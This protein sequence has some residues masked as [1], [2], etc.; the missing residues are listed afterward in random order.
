MPRVVVTTRLG[1]EKVVQVNAGLSLM[2]GLRAAGIDEI[3]AV[4]GGCAACCTCHVYIQADRLNEL[5][6]ISEQED[7]LLDSS[8]ARTECS[9][10]S[11]QIPVTE[12]MDGLRIMVAPEL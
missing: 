2:E 4:C 6:P 12:A 9:R 3:E 5:A 1:H 7:A 8:E 10:L 11:C